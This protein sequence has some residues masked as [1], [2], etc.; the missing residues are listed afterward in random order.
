MRTTSNVK[1]K[2]LESLCQRLNI[3][4][5]SEKGDKEVETYLYIVEDDEAAHTNTEKGGAHGG[6]L[7]LFEFLILLLLLSPWH[8]EQAQK[9]RG[10]RRKNPKQLAELLE[11]MKSASAPGPK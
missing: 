1:H 5:G 11:F 9:T 6:Q 3:K 10:Q 4:V 7:K 8:K 2:S